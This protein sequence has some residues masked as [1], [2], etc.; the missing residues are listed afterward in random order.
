MGMIQWLLWPHLQK[1]KIV[2]TFSFCDNHKP[3]H[4]TDGMGS[5]SGSPLK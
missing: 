5:N 4:S 2:L 3:Q 1:K